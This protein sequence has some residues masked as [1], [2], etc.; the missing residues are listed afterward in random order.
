MYNWLKYNANLCRENQDSL[1]DI[2]Y[3]DQISFTIISEDG[4]MN[5]STI[6]EEGGST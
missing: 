3:I 4:V 2:D 6:G 5:L 1:T